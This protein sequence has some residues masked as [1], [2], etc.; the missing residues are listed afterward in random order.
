MIKDLPV[1]VTQVHKLLTPKSMASALLVS[2]FISSSWISYVYWISKN[3]ASNLGIILTSFIFLPSNTLGI[4]ILTL[5][6]YFFLNVTE[7]GIVKTP[8]PLILNLAII[9]L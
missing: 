4:L 1:F 7:Y 5:V 2:N 8:S 9:K 3:L 6:P